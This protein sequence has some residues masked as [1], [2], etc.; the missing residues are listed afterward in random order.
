MLYSHPIIQPVCQ[1]SFPDVTGINMNNLYTIR[2]CRWETLMDCAWSRMRSATVHERWSQ[3]YIGPLCQ[4]D[5]AYRQIDKIRSRVYSTVC[6]MSVS[7]L[8]ATSFEGMN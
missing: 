6:S 8:D 5:C 4:N 7:N 3:L 1:R 2:C